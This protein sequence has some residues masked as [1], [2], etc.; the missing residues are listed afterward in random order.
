MPPKESAKE[1]KE[2]EKAEALALAQLNER[3]QFEISE[4]KARQGVE[5]AEY[6]ERLEALVDF[7]AHLVHPSSRLMVR[8]TEFQDIRDIME[9]DSIAKTLQVRELT[10]QYFHMKETY[11]A[12]QVELVHLRS[13][14][15]QLHQRVRKELE[16]EAFDA[17]KRELSSYIQR[18]EDDILE[19]RA[20]VAQCGVH[21]HK[22]LET[23]RVRSVTMA[24]A[25]LQLAERMTVVLQQQQSMHTRIPVR[26]RKALTR[27]EKDDL[28]RILDTLSFEDSALQALLHR[29]PPPK[30]DPFTNQPPHFLEGSDDDSQQGIVGEF[31]AHHGNA[32]GP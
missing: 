18:I 2:R 12:L 9:K 16:T 14:C 20:D 30:D 27:L 10:S 4:E 19:H 13:E 6:V 8:Y 21:L 28:V 29:F 31:Q 26:I 11:S 1:R 23:A 15:R 24:D 32:M 5:T 25:T 7:Y 22:A 3:Q 17:V